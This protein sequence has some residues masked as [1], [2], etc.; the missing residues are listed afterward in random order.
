MNCKFCQQP[1][2]QVITAG[3]VEDPGLSD[4]NCKN[5]HVT[6][7]YFHGSNMSNQYQIFCGDW[8]AEF[9]TV[10]NTFTLWKLNKDD[11]PYNGG[12][13]WILDLDFLPNITPQNISELKLSMM[14][15]FS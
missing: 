5:C 9:R 8:I 4:F 14:V 15:T 7:E 10:D 11:K 6:Y 2:D 1:C 13:I 3:S 12:W